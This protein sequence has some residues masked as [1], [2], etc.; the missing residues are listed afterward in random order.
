MLVNWGDWS[1]ISDIWVTTAPDM[2]ANTAVFENWNRLFIKRVLAVAGTTYP[3]SRNVAWIHNH[4]YRQDGGWVHLSEFRFS[5]DGYCSLANIVNFAPFA[6]IPYGPYL[7]GELLCGVP[8]PGEILPANATFG[9]PS[10][11][12]TWE[13]CSC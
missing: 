10:Q 8:T 4:A 3:P 13:S 2:P 6:C 11:N 9:E 12:C 5:D 7:D 1:T